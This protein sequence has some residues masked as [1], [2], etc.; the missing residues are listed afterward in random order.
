MYTFLF[1]FRRKLMPRKVERTIHSRKAFVNRKHTNKKAT[2]ELTDSCGG[3]SENGHRF[4]YLDDWVSAGELFRKFQRLWPCWR[5]C[6]TRLGFEVSKCHASPSLIL[7]LCLYLQLVNQIKARQYCSSTRPACPLGDHGL[8][9][10][11][12]K[13]ASN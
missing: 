5:R 9:L 1:P 11:H 3:L 4:I 13:Q 8:T 6:V 10:Y 7:H 2:I 12:C